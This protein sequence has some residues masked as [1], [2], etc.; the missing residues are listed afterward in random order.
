MSLNLDSVRGIYQ[1][2]AAGDVPAIVA[3]FAPDI[4]WSE[5]EGGPYGG[6]SVGPDAVLGNV[7]MKIGAE[8]DGYAAVPEEFVAQGST[9]VVLGQYSGTYKATG[10][11]FSAP[12]AHV[13]KF[14]DGKVAEFQQHTDTV[15]HQRPLQP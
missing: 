12:F 6:V 9:V 5:A 10:K 1:A 7:F 4:R 8:W 15:L 14:E 3:S 13:W 2:F 11:S